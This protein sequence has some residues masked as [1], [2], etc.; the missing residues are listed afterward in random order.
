MAQLVLHRRAARYFERLDERLKAQLREK[1][2]ELA[3]D[4]FRMPGVKPMQGEWKG[5]YRLRHGDL[6][7]I[8]TFDQATDTVV[9][10]HIGPRGDIYK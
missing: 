9:V 3:R 5:H 7:I 2:T 8:F 6:R 10:G 1:L 4:P